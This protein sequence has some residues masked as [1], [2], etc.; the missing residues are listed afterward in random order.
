MRKLVLM[1]SAP[2]SPR[3][4]V[5]TGF[6]K[7]SDQLLKVPVPLV[8]ELFWMTSIQ[9]PWAFMPGEARQRHLGVERAEERCAAVLD[10]RRR[11]VVEDR[12]A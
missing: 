7:L 1:L 9:V 10:R 8:V 11:V 5:G 4:E 12:V 2:G 6:W 3:P